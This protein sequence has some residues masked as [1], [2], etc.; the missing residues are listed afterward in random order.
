M[1][2]FAQAGNATEA[3]K[4][5]V[6]L[7]VAVALTFNSG[8]SRFWSGV[9]SLTFGGNTYLGAGQMGEIGVAPETTQMRAERKL[10]RMSGVDLSLV[11][12]SDIDA[13]YG[14]DVTE[15]FGFLTK[16]GALVATPEINWEG[17]IDS[18]RR[19]DG[20]TPLIEVSAES[21]M[22]LLDKADGY[23]YTQEHQQLFFAGDN[24]FDQ[25][26]MVG[27]A[28]IMWGGYQV[29]TGG[30]SGAGKP[31]PGGNRTYIP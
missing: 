25:V 11:S 14:L 5:H 19:V 26:A 22:I 4:S 9:G 10:Y 1:T 12:Q 27:A 28:T 13:S 6:S 17:R 23:R 31:G 7:F 8:V 30:N 21:R 15:Y 16:D 29:T 2:W 24:G 18:I 20:E 3:D